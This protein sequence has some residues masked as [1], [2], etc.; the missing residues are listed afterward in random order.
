MTGVQTCA[1]PICLGDETLREGV[2]KAH[3]AAIG[4]VVNFLEDQVVMTRRG[5]NG[6][7]QIDIDGGLIATKFRHWDSRSGDPNLH[8]H[9]VIS[10]RVKGTDGQWSAIDGRTLYQWNVAAS[11]LYNAKLAEYLES[12]LGLMCVPDSS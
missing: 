3:E 4:D 10:N 1:L 5:R 2:Q 11:E 8:D 6:V 9:L 12:E 7:R